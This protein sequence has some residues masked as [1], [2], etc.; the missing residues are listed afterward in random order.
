[1]ARYGVIGS[2]DVGK[3]LALGLK[4]HGHEPHIG[5]RDGKKLAAWSQETGV[6]EG[7]FRAVADQAE[8]V[9]LAVAGAAAE[10]TVRGLAPAL[11]GKVVIDTTNPI[12]GPPVNGILTFFT[13]PNESLLE[14]LQ[15]I[16]PAARF[17]KAFSSVGN[18]L[19]VDPA[20]PGGPPTMFIAGNDA[21]ARAQ[22]T[23]LLA[24]FGWDVEDL[25]A[26]EGARAIEPLCQLWC[27]PGF[28]RNQWSH[29][30]KLLRR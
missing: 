30:F 17:V 14:R 8:V 3:A 23:A 27:A 25:G 19:M 18:A 22:V 4:K 26:A 11:S 24:D 7:T 16:A 20:L 15:R 28:L 1:M 12:G 9:I 13:G 29:A 5:S 10:E 6:L 2:G 21:P